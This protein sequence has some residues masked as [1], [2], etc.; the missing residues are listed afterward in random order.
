MRLA[1]PFVPNVN[2]YLCK[3]GT[4]KSTKFYSLRLQNIC[5]FYETSP[6]TH[7]EKELQNIASVKVIKDSNKLRYELLM[8]LLFGCSVV[9]N[10]FATPWTVARQAPLSM[11]F[12]RQEYW[13][14]LPFPPPGDLPDPMSH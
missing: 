9:S 8:L 14:G 6:T 12:P 10:S 3:P 13:S 1:S 7:L 2:S 4:K 5:Y 11:E